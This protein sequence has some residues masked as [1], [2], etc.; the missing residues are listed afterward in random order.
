MYCLIN[1]THGYDRA[2]SFPCAPCIT[3]TLDPIC[4]ACQFGKAHQH[5]H[6]CQQGIIGE[7]HIIPGAGVSADQM[8][9]GDP[10][11]I[12]TTRGKPTSKCY[13]FCNFCVDHYS[14]F[15]YVT[16]HETKDMLEILKS[17]AEFDAFAAKKYNIKINSYFTLTII[18]LR[19][20]PQEAHCTPGFLW[21]VVNFGYS[22]YSSG[23]FLDHRV[24]GTKT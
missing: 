7:T 12:P 11:R 9:A 13:H 20:V 2:S 10:G 22:H 19:S 18:L 21:I 23:L 14:Q 5:S 1:S 24:F 15:V 17:K 3:N 4:A 8:E 6:I 16:I